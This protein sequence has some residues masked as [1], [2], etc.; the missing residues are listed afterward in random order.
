M[1]R[2]KFYFSLIVTTLCTTVPT[3]AF[4]MV[5]YGFQ[6]VPLLIAIG[7]VVTV[8]VGWIY[9]KY[10]VDLSFSKLL[11][12]TALFLAVAVGDVAGVTMANA[13]AKSDS[14]QANAV[15]KYEDDTKDIQ[16]KFEN[17]A[18]QFNTTLSSQISSLP[19]VA[20]GCVSTM[21]ENAR[22]KVL[23]DVLGVVNGDLKSRPTL[24]ASRVY[25]EKDFD[26]KNLVVKVKN[27]CIQAAVAN[28]NTELTNNLTAAKAV[29]S[30]IQ[31]LEAN[32]PDSGT[33]LRSEKISGSLAATFSDIWL[34]TLFGVG[35]TLFL[36][37]LQNKKIEDMRYQYVSVTP[38][39]DFR[40]YFFNQSNLFH[41]DSI[42]KEVYVV[43]RK[44]NPIALGIRERLHRNFYGKSNVT[45]KVMNEAS[46]HDFEQEFK[47]NLAADDELWVIHYQ[48][49]S[50][51]YNYGLGVP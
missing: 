42:D 23:A 40:D 50:D 30:S 3:F 31:K 8:V 12:T 24:S 39:K 34:I 37:K 20:S 7:L 46:R 38:E 5:V 18:T 36:K 10:I 44:S 41:F 17:V 4:F 48:S 43:I 32:K 1:N 45:F 51:Y 29:W 2:F 21:E 14:N 35:F 15:A 49:L 22:A 11:A 9:H 27:P 25:T 6:M 28:A 13:E 16:T 19:S 47:V 33:K 26:F